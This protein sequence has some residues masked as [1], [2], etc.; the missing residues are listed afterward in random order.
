MEDAD[1]IGSDILSNDKLEINLHMLGALMLNC[2]A[3]K[4]QILEC[5]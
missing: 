2:Y 1:L 3:P 5:D 4:F